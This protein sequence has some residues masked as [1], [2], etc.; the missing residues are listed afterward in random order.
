MVCPR[1]PSEKSI[2]RGSYLPTDLTQ[3][4]TKNHSPLERSVNISKHFG[5]V[6]LWSCTLHSIPFA[7]VISSSLF[8]LMVAKHRYNAIQ[9][10]R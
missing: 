7:K 5:D 4:T 2:E 1:T 10:N 3:F 8:F 6:L 9:Y